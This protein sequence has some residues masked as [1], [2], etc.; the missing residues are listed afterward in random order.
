MT[1]SPVFVFLAD[2]RPP[3]RPRWCVLRAATPGAAVAIEPADAA[4][5][6]A[7]AGLDSGRVPTIDLRGPRA[8]V[9]PIAAW[10]S[11]YAESN[12]GAPPLPDDD[13]PGPDIA[14]IRGALEHEDLLDDGPFDHLADLRDHDVD[15]APEDG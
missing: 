7:A 6:D 12:A 2:L 9:D 5:A 3:G 14:A 15:P 13:A 11:W 1:T 8:Q 4:P 10:D